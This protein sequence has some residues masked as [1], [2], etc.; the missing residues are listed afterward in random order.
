MLFLFAIMRIEHKEIFSHFWNKLNRDGL[1]MLKMVFTVNSKHNCV[2]DAI[3]IPDKD[4]SLEIEQ[5]QPNQP[6][7]FKGKP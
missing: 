2:N 5:I 3:N 4:Y 1:K 7:Q 6:R